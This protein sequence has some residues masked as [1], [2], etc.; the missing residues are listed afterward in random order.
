VE[1][2]RGAKDTV[3]AWGGGVAKD[4]EDVGAWR[5]SANKVGAEVAFRK[6]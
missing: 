1:R 6:G 5:S 3:D 2:D 4:Q